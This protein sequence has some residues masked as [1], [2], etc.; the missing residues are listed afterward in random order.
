MAIPVNI[1][2]LISGTVV[3]SNRIEFKADFNPTPVL[4]AICA[5]ANDIDNIGGGYV[6]IGVEENNG[7]PILPI[8]GIEKDRV[9]GMLKKLL[10]LCHFLEPFYEPQAEPVLFEGRYVI[11]LWCSGGYGRPYKAPKDAIARQSNKYYYIRRFSSNVIASPDEEKELF[12]ISSSIPFD[13]RPNLMASVDD[14]SIGLMRDHLRK[15]GSSLY[16]RSETM[17][18]EQLASDM[19]LLEGPPENRHPRNVGLLLFSDNPQRFFREARIEIVDIPDPSGTNMTEKIFTGPIQQQLA[20]ALLFIRNYILKE[21][22]FKTNTTAEARR[23]WNY[24][25]RAVDELLS[26]AVYHRSYQIREPITVRCTPEGMEITSFP[27]FDRSISEQDIQSQNIRGR[28]YRNRRIGDFLKE[29]HLIEGRNTGFPNAAAA[30]RENG[31]PRL[32]FSMD[33]E[34]QYL[35]VTIPIH[36]AFI[37]PR[38][39]K[40]TAYQNK[41]LSALED[42]ALTL[43]EL[44]TVL[45]YKGI[46]AKLRNT[47]EYLCLMNIIEKDLATGT[48]HR[49]R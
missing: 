46:T 35:S 33:P 24:P 47:L 8:K 12:Y 45:G 3:E 39:R 29:L 30:L 32:Q 5:F 42:K 16:D 15:I 37:N 6:V 27:G 43:T 31:S 26:N 23:V 22:I 18:K 7:T 38:M 19:Q 25:Y 11:V 20:D 48:Y 21:K 2:E 49:K 14:L 36:P 28:I 17:T 44:A 4:H 1:K 34:R 40:A 41:I 13:D 9:D 10:E